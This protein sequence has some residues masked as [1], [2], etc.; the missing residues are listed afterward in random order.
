MIK[1]LNLNVE[2]ICENIL[3]QNHKISG[4]L[5][6]ARAFKPLPEILKLIHNQV[7]KYKKFF[8]F[9]GKTGND[10]L[11]QASKAWDI[12][13]KKR[14]SITNDDSIILEINNL[15]KK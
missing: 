11:L 6:V 12:E 4:E 14:K 2:V 3:E 7:T 1:S 15:R 8:V 5:F 13:Y 9:L 10:E